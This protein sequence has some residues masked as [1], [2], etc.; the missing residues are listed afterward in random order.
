MAKILL[1]E[2]DAAIRRVISKALSGMGHVVLESPN[3]RHAW[4]TLCN[5]E[6]IDMLVTDMAM[7]EM[8]GRQLI[9]VVRGNSLF[10]ALPIL[11]LSGV[12]DTRSIL[13]LLKHGTMA[14]IPKPI[15]MT[16]LV[17]SVTQYLHPSEAK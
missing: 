15:K 14:F 11:I 17:S 2:D 10:A 16:D 8:D 5:N 6:G 9:Q 12:S 4:E 13:D 3:G 7:P 1:A